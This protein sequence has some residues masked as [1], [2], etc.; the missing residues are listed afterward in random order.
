MSVQR[1]LNNYFQEDIA[2]AID[3]RTIRLM[4]PRNL[5]MVEFLAKVL[6]VGVDYQR[7]EKIVIDER[8][9]TIVSGINIKVDPVVI[10]H[11]DITIKITPRKSF[12]SMDLANN[13]DMKDGLS[14]G[15]EQNMLNVED[16]KITVA[17]IARA[18][19][20]LGAKPKDII[21]IIENIKRAG[22]IRAKLEII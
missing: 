2:V 14:I 3:P 5:S 1:G 15:V 11:G 18:L 19:Q 22:A 12:D 6:E 10:T 21:S 9:G 8:T 7:E 13:V 16:D 4:K 20:K 17:N